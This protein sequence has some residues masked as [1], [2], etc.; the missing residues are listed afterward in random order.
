MLKTERAGDNNL[1]YNFVTSIVPGTHFSIITRY[2]REGV[3]FE[4]EKA[5]ETTVRT[6]C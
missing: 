3:V 4:N 2:C 6:H 1:V 5:T